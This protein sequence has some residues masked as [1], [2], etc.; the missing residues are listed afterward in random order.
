VPPSNSAVSR[1]KEIES[2]SMDGDTYDAYVNPPLP[3]EMPQRRSTAPGG[4]ASGGQTKAN[5]K[6]AVSPPS[7]PLAND[8]D[9][10][11]KAAA[12]RQ[13]DA[14]TAVPKNDPAKNAGGASAT[15][16]SNPPTAPAA[17][18]PGPDLEPAPQGGDGVLRRESMRPNYARVRSA[19]RRNILFG[20]VENDNGVPRPEVPVIVVNRSNTF[21]RHSGASDAFGTF[22]IRVP[23]GQWVV[24]VT[25]P[26][27]NM[28]SV[29]SITVTDGMVVDNQEGRE[30]QNLIISF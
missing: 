11:S 3:D 29:R 18:D 19:A 23:D 13:G 21:I 6:S 2:S 1:G 24:R 7:T 26:S 16:K 9:A 5:T 17:D 14:A 30:V 22:A 4:Q 27:G 12:N 20:T 25:M 15:K 10:A 28:Q 8:V